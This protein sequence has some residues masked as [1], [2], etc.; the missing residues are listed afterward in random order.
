MREISVTM[1]DDGWVVGDRGTRKMTWAPNSSVAKVA[2]QAAIDNPNQPAVD[3]VRAMCYLLVDHPARFDA[4]RVRLKGIE[5]P[6]GVIPI[7]GPEVEIEDTA[8]RPWDET[9]EEP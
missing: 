4:H 9:E 5:V 2:I 7:L 3:Y 6:E 1:R 8:P